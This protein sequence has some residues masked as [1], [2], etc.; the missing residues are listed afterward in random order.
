V[1]SKVTR[2]HPI[3][4]LARSM[5]VE[6]FLKNTQEQIKKIF[7]SVTQKGLSETENL[8]EDLV[9]N[10]F[11]FISEKTSKYNYKDTP[12]DTRFPN[13]LSSLHDH[14]VL[15]AAIASNIIREVYERYNDDQKVTR[16]LFFSGNGPDSLIISKKEA[17]LMAELSGLFHDINKPRL[18]EHAKQSANLIGELLKDFP[19]NDTL[20][21]IIVNAIRLHHD[22]DDKSCLFNEVIRLADW[23]STSERGILFEPALYKNITN[24]F[25]IKTEYSN[26]EFLEALQDESGQKLREMKNFRGYKLYLTTKSEIRN[27]FLFAREEVFKKELGLGNKPFLSL[28]YCDFKSIQKFIYSSDKLPVVCGAS[29]FV[30][31]IEKEIANAFSNH[32]RLSKSSVIC[33]GGGNVLVLACST[34]IE[35]LL[36]GVL[37]DAKKSIKKEIPGYDNVIDEIFAKHVSIKRPIK[38]FLSEIRHGLV[39]NY[40]DFDEIVRKFRGE[41]TKL[42]KGYLGESFS[43]RKESEITNQELLYKFL[44]RKGFGEVVNACLTEPTIKDDDEG[45]KFTIS[46]IFDNIIF[47]EWCHS[48]P[49]FKEDQDPEGGS[50]FICEWCNFKRE[51]NKKIEED[52][53]LHDMV[54]TELIQKVRN[55]LKIDLTISLPKTIDHLCLVKPLSDVLKKEVDTDQFCI[56]KVDGNNFGMIKARMSSPNMYRAFSEFIDEAAK[57]S[58]K[59]ALVETIFNEINEYVQKNKRDKYDNETN[60]TLN[61]IAP[62]QSVILG[63]D[64]IELFLNARIALPFVRNF[65]RNIRLKFGEAAILESDG[66]IYKIDHEFQADPSNLVN[67]GDVALSFFSSGYSGGL[68]FADKKTPLTILN[69]SINYLESE[70]KHYIKQKIGALEKSGK[71][72]FGAWNS[73]ALFATPSN[74]Y[75]ES[76]IEYI[77]RGVQNCYKVTRFPMSDLEFNQFFKE[78]ERYNQIFKKEKKIVISRNKLKTIVFGG[79]DKSPN[80]FKL[81]LY[82]LAGKVDPKKDPNVIEFLDFLIQNMLKKE[83]KHYIL[84]LY[85]PIL[86]SKYLT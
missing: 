46:N 86:Y 68:I 65:F 56:F 36:E 6:A 10:L 24:N 69:E 48:R 70:A 51:V 80:E 52:Y 38:L 4:L 31:V 67:A 76:H 73:I 8:L 19:I 20:K 53:L 50:N 27:S 9:N 14:M 17:I 29:K 85:D 15:V 22:S 64:D 42:I 77:Y 55:D 45:I 60:S 39:E 28:L 81:Q 37:D 34:N 5:D 71:K 83:K 66:K 7:T 62:F 58:L 74:D 21:K 43:G 12:A 82:Y 26:D 57:E 3:T 16:Y 11:Q 32:N 63:G 13:S 54:K 79:L 84:N 33:R 75:E 2:F 30:T 78:L 49:A 23:T 25:D 1:S 41:S 72:A 18:K 35:N 61:M 44:Q 47:C 40:Y 59:D